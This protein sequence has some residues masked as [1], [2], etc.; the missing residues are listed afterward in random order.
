M[1]PKKIGDPIDPEEVTYDNDEGHCLKPPSL[2][3][4]GIFNPDHYDGTYVGIVGH[5]VAKSSP[6]HSTLWVRIWS[7]NLRQSF[8][9]LG[10]AVH[11][12][13]KLCTVSCR[14]DKKIRHDGSWQPGASNVV[15]LSQKDLLVDNEGHVHPM[16]TW[17]TGV[18]KGYHFGSA[19]FAL[20]TDSG[21]SRNNTL[22]LHFETSSLV[23][24]SQVLPVGSPVRYQT[25][26]VKGQGRKQ[27]SAQVMS[28]MYDEDRYPLHTGP[29]PSNALLQN[30]ETEIGEAHIIGSC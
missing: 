6:N 21:M 23:H 24:G 4:L 18:I 3:N 25:A 20:E 7:P 26:L 30:A 16:Q 22:K 29:L 28:L 19:Q 27:D 2:T 13:P 12:I 10:K 9:A 5:I 14:Q 8:I 1:L 15:A 11:N 17:G